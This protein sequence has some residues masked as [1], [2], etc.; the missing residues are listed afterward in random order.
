[1]TDTLFALPRTVRDV[2]LLVGR[3]LLGIILIAHGWQK[4]G[5][6]GLTATADG[7][8]KMGVPAP[9]L[10]AAFSALVELV[11][12]SLILL[13][14]LTPVVAL[15]V[16]L[17]MLGAFLFVHVGKGVFAT[18]GGWELVAVIA[19]A[20]LAFA[21]GPGR[22]SVDA[23]LARRRTDRGEGRDEVVAARET[24]RR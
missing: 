3:I 2:V 11:G 20:A 7:F 24:V 21:V 4:L 16:A 1:M 17:D 10:S 18:E 8:E 13:G 12:G 6:N 19:V 14:A 5:T 9:Q 15:L 22:F 23:L